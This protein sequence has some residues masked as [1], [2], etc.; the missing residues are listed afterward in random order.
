MA[1]MSSEGKSLGN[2]QCLKLHLSPNLH[3]SFVSR[4][5]AQYRCD[6]PGGKNSFFPVMLTMEPASG[7][8][9]PLFAL[10]KLLFLDLVF[11]S[12]R[13]MSLLLR[14]RVAPLDSLLEPLRSMLLP[15][16]PMLSDL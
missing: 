1:A 12:G 5:D 8:S 10:E 4:N 11:W 3:A 15:L 7:A 2:L 13:L 16:P 6:I 9:A 14:L